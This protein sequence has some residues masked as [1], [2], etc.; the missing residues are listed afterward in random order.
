MSLREFLGADFA[1]LPPDVLERCL[2]ID[3]RRV[4]L[5][6]GTGFFGKQLLSL[7]DFLYARGA[8]FSVVSISREPERFLREHAEFSTLPWLRFVATDLAIGVPP[9]TAADLL[10]HAGTD[11]RAN[12]HLD[13]IASFNGQVEVTRHTLEHAKRS[14]V[15]RLLLCGSGA[16]YPDK[17]VRT[18]LG[19]Q[20]AEAPTCDP[21]NAS[22]GY[23]EAKRVDESL[24]A[25][26]GR[27]TG[28]AVINTRCFA[29]VGPGLPLTGH[30][31]IGNF[32]NDGLAGG[33][34]R[35]SSAGAALRSYLYGADLAVWLLLL[36]LEAP[37]GSAVNVGSDRPISIGELARLVASV[38]D[39]KMA[40]RFGAAP[41]N[42]ARL[43]Y[44]PHTGRARALGL[45]VWTPIETA[46]ARTAAYA[47]AAMS[48]AG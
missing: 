13:P 41:D 2:R 48:G 20:E 43:H 4:V 37:S 23:G 32:I 38:L 26:M 14:G 46:I 16:Q 47:R 40:V 6:G 9:P 45:E 3:G 24:A 44:W 29:F 1:A 15:E 21:S 22:G 36:L 28:C 11:T 27:D 17:P 12:A 19:F 42:A 7:F 25:Q 33:P 18:D 10:I 34:V 5:T 39:P 8:R 31:A 35:V 30:F